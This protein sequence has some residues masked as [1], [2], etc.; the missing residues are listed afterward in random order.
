MHSFFGIKN[1]LKLTS[2]IGKCSHLDRIT[3]FRAL[4]LENDIR[5]SN[6]WET[7]HVAI[8][9]FETEVSLPRLIL[10]SLF[11]AIFAFKTFKASFPAASCSNNWPLHPKHDHMRA[12]YV[13]FA[14]A[15]SRRIFKATFF[16]IEFVIIAKSFHAATQGK[17]EASYALKTKSN[18]SRLLFLFPIIAR[19][20][21]HVSKFS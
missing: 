5:I 9:L 10:K 18:A 2:A 15:I 19:M 8:N 11:G 16:R 17:A 4:C 20:H 14:F 1:L 13:R 21:A 7:M 12:S 3:L 6:F